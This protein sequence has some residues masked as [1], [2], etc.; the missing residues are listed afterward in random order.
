MCRHALR[1]QVQVLALEV[2]GVGSSPEALA[3]RDA[4]RNHKDAQ[5]ARERK[6]DRTHYLD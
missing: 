4:K 5:A 1:S 3:A 6:V 2:W